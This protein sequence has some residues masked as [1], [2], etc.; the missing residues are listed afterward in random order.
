MSALW[1]VTL[2]DGELVLRPLRHSDRRAWTE[3][4]RRNEAW[5]APWE[6]TSPQGSELPQGFG[7]LVR[8]FAA[9]GRRGEAL[10]WVIEVAG[11]LAGQLTVGV[12]LWGSLRSANAG[13]WVDE[14]MAGRGI[15]PHALALA[16]DHCLFGLGLH[17]IEVNIRPENA[18]S[19][20]VVEK[21]GFRDEGLRLRYLHVAGRWCDHRSFA[22]TVE[23]V[24]DG[25]ME[26]WRER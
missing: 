6:A 23:D 2:R 18:A 4:R 17:R 1:P 9:Q 11:Q 12:I 15:A 5:L 14:R 3:L 16:C 22:V 10:P 26:R 20:R 21:L 19:L 25:L 8:L 24:P 7:A 13:Y